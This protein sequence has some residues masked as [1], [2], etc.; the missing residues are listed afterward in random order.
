MLHDF[1]DLLYSRTRPD[2]H[3]FVKA[4]LYE[5]Y[6]VGTP[7]LIS[8]DNWLHLIEPGVCLEMGIVLVKAHGAPGV[9]TE[10]PYCD[11][12]KHHSHD[13]GKASEVT[14]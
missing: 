6:E 14:W 8:C 12:R 7:R 1:L 13:D 5:L 11:E 10:C 9:A 4:K 2:A 3:A